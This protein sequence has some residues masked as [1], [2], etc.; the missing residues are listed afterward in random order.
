MN[1]KNDVCYE[2]RFKLDKWK[3]RKQKQKEFDREFIKKSLDSFLKEG[4]KIK[5]SFNRGNK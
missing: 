5:Q 1:K 4:G 2:D 3:F